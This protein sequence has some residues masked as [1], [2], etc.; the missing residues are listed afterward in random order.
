[1][2]RLH[3]I[4]WEINSTTDGMEFTTY[5]GSPTIDTT[6]KRSGLSSGR[7]SSMSSAT[8]KYFSLTYSAGTVNNFVRV[9]VYFATLPSAENRFLVLN[10]ANNLTT[11]LVYCTI[12]NTGV[13]KLYDEDGQITGTTTLSAGTWYRLEVGANLTGAGSTDV[14]TGKIDGTNF[15]TSSTRNI[16]AN[17]TTLVLGGNL[18]SEAQTTGDWYFD[19]LGINDDSD[20]TSNTYPGAG[21]VIV[22]FG[23]GA[24][25]SNQWTTGAARTAG[26]TNNYQNVD[27]NPPNDATDYIG[28][29]T[30]NNQ[31]LYTISPTAIVTGDTI[32]LTMINCRWRNDVATSS[33][34]DV[35][36][37]YVTSGTDTSTSNYT[38][39]STSWKTNAE[40]ASSLIT[41]RFLN[42]TDFAGAAYTKA[43]IDGS[44]IGVKLT[45]GTSANYIE[46]SAI[47]L[48]VEYIATPSTRRRIYI[49]N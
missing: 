7:I 31:D 8:A 24:G 21:N 9:Y 4:G 16:S 39:N 3:T 5:S 27:D 41:P 11:P 42:Y 22:A 32:T 14:I 38:L 29:T 19:D 25:A 15:A 23:T 26:T 28:S 48:V 17:P 1:M 20:T 33:G 43:T 45:T 49:T 46:I 18:N 2:G 44:K 37:N 30:V 6:I 13:I 10:D 34:L 40:N 47:W 12:D 35:Q 36:I